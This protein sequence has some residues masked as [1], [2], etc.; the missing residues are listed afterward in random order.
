MTNLAKLL[1]QYFEGQTTGRQNII[2]YRYNKYYSVT[3]FKKN[4][5]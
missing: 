3:S 5:S 2:Q 1:Y 4:P